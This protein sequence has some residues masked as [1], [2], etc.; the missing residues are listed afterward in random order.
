MID[1]SAI[2]FDCLTSLISLRKAHGAEFLPSDFDFS[3]LFADR[4]NLDL[5]VEEDLQDLA[6]VGF[7]LDVL[8]SSSSTS[9][10]SASPDNTSFFSRL[11]VHGT[12]NCARSTSLSRGVDRPGQCL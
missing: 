9:S 7:N 2:L 1:V 10:S 3:A 6:I 12:W 4:P 5:A 8:S 11:I